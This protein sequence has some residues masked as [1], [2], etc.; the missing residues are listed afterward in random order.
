MKM[1]CN[2]CIPSTT[3][4]SGI[5]CCKH[6]SFGANLG[7]DKSPNLLFNV[8]QK[9]TTYWPSPNTAKPSLKLW[10]DFWCTWIVKEFTKSQVFLSF[11]P[12][13]RESA[14]KV[15]IPGASAESGLIHTLHYQQQSNTK[16][17]VWWMIHKPDV[18]RSKNCINFLSSSYRIVWCNLCA[19]VIPYCRLEWGG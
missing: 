2:S 4:G 17:E 16:G 14:K 1:V 10:M 15:G 6:L 7:R 13:K 11:L 9:G 3:R 19:P 8:S 12:T 18:A 5:P